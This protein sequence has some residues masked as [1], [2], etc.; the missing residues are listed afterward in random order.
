[1]SIVEKIMVGLQEAEYG[2]YRGRDGG[3]CVRLLSWP[4]LASYDA[5]LRMHRVGFVEVPVRVSASVDAYA[6]PVDRLHDLVDKARSMID[7]PGL[8]I[9][10][11]NSP[12]SCHPPYANS[13]VDL[14][15]FVP[16]EQVAENPHR[17]AAWLTTAKTEVAPVLAD[18]LGREVSIG[19]LA[20]ELRCMP[21]MA[22]AVDADDLVEIAPASR[23]AVVGA[24]IERF[25]ACGGDVRPDL[26]RLLD[27]LACGPLADPGGPAL[28]VGPR[29]FDVPEL[30]LNRQRLND[31]TGT[32]GRWAECPPRPDAR[33]GGERL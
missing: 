8:A 29:W 17:W 20:N 25:L 33:E 22:D 30:F 11:S 23:A 18:Y 32:G 19:L 7:L 12:I 1:V 26:L 6:V 21:G 27:Y 16:V 10:G 5:G 3:L 9:C 15:C 31:L 2:I 28:Y 4:R 13:D 14:V 24:H